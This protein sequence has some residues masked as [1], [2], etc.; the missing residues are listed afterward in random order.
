MDIQFFNGNYDPKPREEVKIEAVRVA[1]YP[2]GQRVHVE[3]DI[4]PFRERPNL[5]LAIHDEQ[6]R[7]VNEL[8]IIETMHFNMEFTMHLRGLKNTVGV[9]SLTVEMFYESRT[10]PHDKQIQGFRIDEPTADNE[11]F[12]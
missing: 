6:D 11:L 3:V 9:Y 5:L 1:P 12:G 2:D 4:T 7:V 10:P 8:T